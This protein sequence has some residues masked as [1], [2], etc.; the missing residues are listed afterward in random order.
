[1]FSILF[2]GIRRSLFVFILLALLGGY[3]I[4]NALSHWHGMPDQAWLGGC[5][6]NPTLQDPC[7]G[8]ASTSTKIHIFLPDTIYAGYTYTLRISVSNRSPLDSAGG[9]DLDVDTPAMLDTVPNMD[10]RLTPFNIHCGL[11]PIRSHN[12][13]EPMVLTVTPPY[14]RCFIQHD[15]L[16]DSTLFMPLGTP[17]TMTV[18]V[19]ISPTI[20]IL[21][22]RSL[23]CS[24]LPALL[25]RR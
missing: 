1:M 17:W 20:G 25:L 19:P 24:P 8:P 18:P 12:S 6:G 14:G 22:P 13:F 10:T 7:H 16:R 21:L 9:F 11:S 3:A 15:Q 23:P 2:R 4:D 5:D